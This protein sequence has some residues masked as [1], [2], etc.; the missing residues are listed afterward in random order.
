M[1][2]G[3]FGE[4]HPDTKSA[5]ARLAMTQRIMGNNIRAEDSDKLISH[6]SS[7][8]PSAQPAENHDDSTGDRKRL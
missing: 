2:K 1:R 3:I 7:D 5:M 4:E 8:I 6:S